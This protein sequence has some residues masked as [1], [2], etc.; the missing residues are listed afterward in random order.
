VAGKP[1]GR[2]SRLIRAS[3]GIK[4]VNTVLEA[5]ARDLAVLKGYVAKLAACPD[6]TP[7]T[8]ES[9]VVVSY[10]LFQ[11]EKSFR[12]SKHDLQARPV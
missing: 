9:V 12:M 8:V 6:G 10:R 3:G 5:K 7:V 2:R 1:A 11:T 4:T